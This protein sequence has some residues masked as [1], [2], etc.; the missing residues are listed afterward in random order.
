MDERAPEITEPSPTFRPGGF[1]QI[2]KSMLSGLA[3]A[4]AA[5]KLERLKVRWKDDY[6]T[7]VELADRADVRLQRAATR[8]G[9]V[10]SMSQGVPLFVNAGTYETVAY[11]LDRYEPFTR[12]LFAS[13]LRPGMRV[14]DLGAQFGIYTVLAARKSPGGEVIAF[15]PEPHNFSL[16]E[17]NVRLNGVSRRVKAHRLAVGDEECVVDFFVYRDSDSHAIHRHP[18]A[19][20]KQ[21]IRQEVVTIDGFLDSPAFDLVKIDIEGHEPFALEG[22]RKSLEKSEDVVLICELA[23]EYLRRA[24][25]DPSDYLQQLRSYGFDA[26][27]IDEERKLVRKIDADFLSSGPPGRAVNLLCR[28]R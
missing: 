24:G 18:D 2:A 10:F 11:S 23:P 7:L 14:L 26:R 27:M 17:L 19:E 28:R 9:V 16:L 5:P 15:E 20:V 8:S 22:M 6:L 1:I 25:V 4:F 3:Y 21:V 13:Y 12:E